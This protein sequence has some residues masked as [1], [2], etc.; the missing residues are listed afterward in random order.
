MA[1]QKSYLIKLATK[2]GEKNPRLD[3]ERLRSNA[4]NGIRTAVQLDA[5]VFINILDHQQDR[6]GVPGYEK[7]VRWGLFDFV[8]LIWLC[9]KESIPLSIHPGIALTEVQGDP[10]LVRKD[11][12]D[13]LAAYQLEL[14][15]DPSNLSWSSAIPSKL[16]AHLD[17]C[18]FF[19][20]TPDEQKFRAC[21]FVSLLAML[22]VDSDLSLETPM[23]RIRRYL[24][25]MLEFVGVF[26]VKETMIACF[27][28]GDL[29][30]RAAAGGY[31]VG[32]DG[33]VFYAAVLRNFARRRQGRKPLG[34][35]PRTSTEVFHLAFNS[36]NDIAQINAGIVMEDRGLDG[37]R[38]D[39]WFCTMDAKLTRF[40]GAMTY[41]KLIPGQAGM[42]AEL[43]LP[44]G[45]AIHPDLI[46]QEAIVFARQFCGPERN[47]PQLSSD[48][49]LVKAE[50]MATLVSRAFPSS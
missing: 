48:I 32:N 29:V 35:R 23:S 20:L 38:W 8:E 22:V 47:I 28:L 5:N 30:E 18:G 39:L 4:A 19:K 24:D 34:R 10:N 6:D 11:Y 15:D 37:E 31:S 2:L 33:E 40:L 36:A 50:Q 46:T 13:F 25:L 3:I 27:V 21:S 1:E 9:N 43:G 45:I 41:K 7:L 16:P 26:S 14:E 42:F 49:W 12:D 44:R 17:N